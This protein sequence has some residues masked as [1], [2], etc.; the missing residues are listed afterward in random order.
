MRLLILIFS[1]ACTHTI[2]AQ[3]NILLSYSIGIPN[4]P[5]VVYLSENNDGSF[6]GFVTAEFWK[7]EKYIFKIIKIKN[8][9]TK[10]ITIQLPSDIVK[11]AIMDLRSGGIEQ[12]SK[13]KNDDS[14]YFLDG[15]FLVF[16]LFYNKKIEKV[17]IPEIAPLNTMQSNKEKDGRRALAQNL[18]TIIDNN[19]NLKGIFREAQKQMKTPYSYSC[20][21]ISICTVSKKPIKKIARLLTIAIKFPTLNPSTLTTK[22]FQKDR[23][24][25]HLSHNPA[26]QFH[27]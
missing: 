7:P 15:D 20:G 12:F 2:F 5:Q 27:Q 4:T 14:K 19:I 26:R 9:R 6:K 3:E 1:L 21:G 25:R 10:K 16:D 18:L 17:E 22:H 23:A 11:K 24:R 13:Y 8:L